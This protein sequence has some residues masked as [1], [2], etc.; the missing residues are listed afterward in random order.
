MARI[1]TFKKLHIDI[2]ELH[3]R[4][5]EDIQEK[6]GMFTVS[7]A[8]R[9]CFMETHKKEFPDYIQVQKDRISNKET[10]EER[11]KR[12][13]EESEIKDRT[14]AE[15]ARSIKANICEELDGETEMINQQPHCKYYMY[16]EVPGGTIEK[17]PMTEPYDTLTE[18][19][20]LL[21]Y[22]DLMGATGTAIKEKLQ[23]KL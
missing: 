23:K 12:V 21:Q 16:T 18:N 19:S 7:D 20:I 8:A 5:L 22:R 1:Q 10:P 13:I 4:V 11:V 2:T 14:K 17:V 3:Y 9:Y 15:K 6:R